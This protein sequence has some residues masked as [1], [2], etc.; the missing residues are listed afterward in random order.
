MLCD[1]HVLQSAGKCALPRSDLRLRMRSQ[2][3]NLYLFAARPES[4]ILFS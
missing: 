2:I 4:T 1:V 3:L